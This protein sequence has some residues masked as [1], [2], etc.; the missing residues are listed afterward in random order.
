MTSGPVY[1]GAV[2]L[3]LAVLGMFV[4]RGRSNGGCS[5]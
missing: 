1:L 2:A 4:L 5:S 3:L